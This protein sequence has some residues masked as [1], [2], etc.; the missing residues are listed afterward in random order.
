M[1]AWRGNSPFGDRVEADYARIRGFICVVWNRSDLFKRALEHLLSD[2]VRFFHA[3]TV[4]E[5][6][7]SG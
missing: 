3:S 6:F 1:P 2:P 5:G 7:E 4:K